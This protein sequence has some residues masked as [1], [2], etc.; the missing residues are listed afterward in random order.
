MKLIIIFFLI[1]LEIISI[2][3]TPRTYQEELNYIRLKNKKFKVGIINSEL[4]EEVLNDKSLNSLSNSFFKDYLKLNVEFYKGNENDI[5]KLFIDN[6]LDI[7]ALIKKGSINDEDVL[8]SEDIKRENN[9]LN[10]GVKSNN[11]NLL[12][13]INSGLRDN[14]NL[15]FNEFSQEKLKELKKNFFIE[16]LTEEE[17]NFFL[18]KENR[19]LKIAYI[20]CESL[21]YY[22][23]SE[24]KFIGRIPEIIKILKKDLDFQIVEI[25]TKSGDY[26]EIYDLF[27]KKKI[28]MIVTS[29]CKDEKCLEK[30]NYI[31]SKEL[32]KIPIY[33][34][35]NN[36]KL[37]VNESKVGVVKNSLESIGV[38][39]VLVSQ[40]IK[41]YSSR[42]RL[43]SS[44]LNNTLKSIALL[45]I[46]KINK[47]NIRAK[48]IG[49]MSIYLG[50]PKEDLVKR[51]L[52]NKILEHYIDFKEIEDSVEKYKNE[53][54]ISKNIENK[55]Y[56][57]LSRI[58]LVL[59]LLM[60]VV[61]IVKRNKN[62]EIEK[63]I[64]FDTLTG[65]FSRV[66][67]NRFCEGFK[68]KKGVAVLIDLDNFKY[69]NDN[70]GHHIGDEILVEYAKI[71]KKVFRSN[72][73]E[74]NIFRIS[75]DEFYC[76]IEKTDY[77]LVINELKKELNESD[78]L[79]KYCI[80]SS[81]GIYKKKE[82]ESV[83]QSFMYADI[84]MCKAKNKKGHT[85]YF[86][87]NGEILKDSLMMLLKKILKNDKYSL[88]SELKI[89][90]DL[91]NVGVLKIKSNV[92]L[93]SEILG[94]V[95][96]RDFIE[97][98]K[99]MEIIKKVDLKVLET[100]LKE[101]FYWKE[102]NNIEKE[103][104][105][106]INLH[107]KIFEDIYLW[108]NI[109]EIISNYKKENIKIKIIIIE[110]GSEILI[111]QL[112]NNLYSLKNENILFDLNSLKVKTEKGRR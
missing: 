12:N 31:L 30:N 88:K 2:Q 94:E 8:Y 76:F 103:I 58:S 85:E 71:I 63:Q 91:V 66:V 16:S 62:F 112:F 60:V 90:S 65:L 108:K 80:G 79:K 99:E 92:I 53:V 6:N 59:L 44:F 9:I 34:I 86:V 47:K 24:E 95:R 109:D 19:D 46:N 29:T 101:T 18:Q 52:I 25:K 102:K 51:D 68:S 45:D 49:N 82:K 100:I 32:F 5:Q 48:V 106:E 11:K 93:E 81:I 67:F 50:F 10:F 77:E 40:N 35:Y 3:Y 72:Y 41:Y 110:D 28:N 104:V 56:I 37:D 111:E 107:L 97:V 39:D 78:I 98:S 55:N 64:T 20:E 57:L 4:N 83:E 96:Y 54:V 23:R 73:G 61:M 36:I 43:M 75:G 74:K 14:Y 17:K 7:V 15:I 27:L 87:E 69:A 70:Y 1:S 13:L 42:D 33:E 38:K 22:S 84:G 26:N 89:E 21:S 105:I